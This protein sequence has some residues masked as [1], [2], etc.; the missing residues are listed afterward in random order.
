[1]YQNQKKQNSLHSFEKKAE[2]NYGIYQNANF[3]T[4]R[5]NNTICP[6]IC[7]VHLL[8]IGDVGVAVLT[9]KVYSITG[10]GQLF[11]FAFGFTYSTFSDLQCRKRSYCLNAIV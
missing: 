5:N 1:M 7:C 6:Y 11:L 9:R 2:T 8:Q 4:L 3:T 10:I